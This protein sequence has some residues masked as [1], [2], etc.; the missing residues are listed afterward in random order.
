MVALRLLTTPS[1]LLSRQ[2]DAPVRRRHRL[3]PLAHQLL[4]LRIQPDFLNAGADEAAREFGLAQFGVSSGEVCR[5][6]CG[7]S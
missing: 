4:A 3:P 2:T 1:Q 6:V 5:T 7:L